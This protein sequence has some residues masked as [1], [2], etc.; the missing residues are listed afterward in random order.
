MK[1]NEFYLETGQTL[2]LTSDASTRV[3]TGQGLD[4]GGGQISLTLLLTAHPIQDR[5]RG[6][7]R[8]PAVFAG[9]GA[10][11]GAPGLLLAP[12]L[13]ELD[14]PLEGG[15]VSRGSQPEQLGAAAA[16]VKIHLDR[17]LLLLEHLPGV[18]P[19]LP[20]QVEEPVAVCAQ[21]SAGVTQDDGQGL[22]VIMIVTGWPLLTPSPWSSPL[23]TAQ[24][25]HV[26]PL[27]YRQMRGEY[28]EY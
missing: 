27:K 8:G 4:T 10:R 16:L 28:S 12:V 19:G 21:V 23:P 2:G 5:H 6:T 22:P 9:D 20:M 17:L 15:A 13:P 3:T 14:H 24:T 26:I 1:G 25:L 7:A 11:A 18:V